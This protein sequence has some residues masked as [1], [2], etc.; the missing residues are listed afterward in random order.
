MQMH[1]MKPD[2]V[3][4][5]AELK[6]EIQPLLEAAQSAE[7]HSGYVSLLTALHIDALHFTSILAWLFTLECTSLPLSAYTC[8]NTVCA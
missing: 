2:S 7:T 8:R 1:S 4:Q 3:E 5:R 6:Q